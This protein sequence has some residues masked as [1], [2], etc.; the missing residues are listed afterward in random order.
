MAIKHEEYI[1]LNKKQK[2]KGKGSKKR[3]VPF[4]EDG[5]QYQVLYLTP[6]PDRLKGPAPTIT[7]IGEGKDDHEAVEKQ[8][9][10]DYPDCELITVSYC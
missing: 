5:Q 9:R 10:K 3:L 2:A 6:G 7:Y 4:F 8:F 1:K